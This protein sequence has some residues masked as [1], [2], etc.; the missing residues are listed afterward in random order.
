MVHSSTTRLMLVAAAV[1]ASVSFF[2]HAQAQQESQV[3]LRRGNVAMEGATN[4]GSSQ[5][6]DA[7][8]D[9]SER[10]CVLLKN[11]NVLFGEAEQV[12][13]FVVIRT[14]QAGEIRLSRSD[15]A[16]WA[17]SLRNL[18]RFRVDHR[19]NGDV[20]THLSD[21]RWCLR[22]D[23][24]DLAAAELRLVRQFDSD[25]QQADSIEQQLRRQ[26]AP[27]PKAT[28][29]AG[30]SSSEPSKTMVAPVS[31]DGERPAS[32]PVDPTTLRRF[33]SHVQ[34]MLINRCGSCHQR[35]M[36]SEENAWA[37]SLPSPG[38]RASSEMTRTNLASSIEYLDV[39][40]PEASLLLIKATEPHG[41]AAAP[42]NA[43]NAKAIW[44]FQQW[45]LTATSAM[46]RAKD[47]R[48]I[49]GRSADSRPPERDGRVDGSEPK[50]DRR[51]GN[52]GHRDAG[53][54]DDGSAVS[55]AS[56]DE[57]SSSDAFVEQRETMTLR[58][59][60]TSP[61][62]PRRLPQVANPFDPDLFNR[63]FHPDSA[64]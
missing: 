36:Q 13:E 63:R 17:D 28:S 1:T 54:G 22:Y 62:E 32:D 33:A 18:Y 31:F 15:V 44:S 56:V 21:A 20:L 64:E 57:P 7:T 26:V 34:P 59:D 9:Q 50:N 42:L 52:A 10:P 4:P 49:A 14:G 43:R 38:S 37:L 53:H 12:G 30:E 8:Q 11:D 58:V 60:A 51:D 27:A 19:T 46:A 61:S 2:A 29:V 55:N 40:V 16:C 6:Q 25:N 45:I 24:Y 39:D 41:G 5:S 3:T 23:L 48:R 35:S 47:R